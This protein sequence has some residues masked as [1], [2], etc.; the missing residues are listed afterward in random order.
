MSAWSRRRAG[1]DG[2]D[3]LQ[4]APLGDARAIGAPEMCRTRRQRHNPKP[5][6]PTDARIA[7]TTASS[8]PPALCNSPESPL[9]RLSHQAGARGQVARQP[10]TL[11]TNVRNGVDLEE[12][13][14]RQRAN[15]CQLLAD[16]DPS[17]A[18]IPQS[19]RSRRGRAAAGPAAPDRGRPASARG[20]F[21]PG[22]RD[23]PG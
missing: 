1:A 15:H 11:H 10:C 6:K 22:G 12:R 18:M 20:L 14:A 9:P 5:K 3:R 21:R 8:R 7:T 19:S 17:L 23:V 2:G 13:A 16:T 4:H